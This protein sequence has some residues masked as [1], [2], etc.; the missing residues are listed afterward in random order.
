MPFGLLFMFIMES[1]N[2]LCTFY[3]N[4]EY[5]FDNVVKMLPRCCVVFFRV[6]LTK[7]SFAQI[8]VV[9]FTALAIYFMNAVAH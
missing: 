5:G 6:Y 9:N 7:R 1:S 3:N 8:L 2:S 4:S